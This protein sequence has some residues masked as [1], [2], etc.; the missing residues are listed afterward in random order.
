MP[1]IQL[2]SLAVVESTWL[3]IEDADCSFKRTLAK[4]KVII[5]MMMLNKG[6]FYLILLILL[7]KSGCSRLAELTDGYT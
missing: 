1:A 2:S 5:C 3:T 6:Q 4:E 7:V